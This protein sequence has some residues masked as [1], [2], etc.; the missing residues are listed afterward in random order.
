VECLRSFNDIEMA[1]HQ[2]FDEWFTRV[3]IAPMARATA[4]TPV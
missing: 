2:R 3:E 1:G 4:A